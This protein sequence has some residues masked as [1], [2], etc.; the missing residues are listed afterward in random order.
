[1]VEATVIGRL[2]GLLRRSEAV[3]SM[4]DERATADVN[5][6]S[7]IS[8]GDRS[9]LKAAYVDLIDQ[10]LLA[11]ELTALAPGAKVLDFGCGV[12]RLACWS[13]FDRLQYFGVDRSQKMIDGAKRHTGE[14]PA[15]LF[16]HYDGDRLPFDDGTFDCVIA[17]WV[18]QH[19][20]DEQSL[21]RTARE[22]DRVSR[23]GGKIILI[24]QVSEEQIDEALPSG[25]IYKRHRPASALSE[26]FGSRSGPAWLRKTDG[27]VMHGPFYRGLA[28]LG[29][30]P[31]AG[32]RK[33]VP[34]FVA[35]DDAWYRA[36]GGLRLPSQRWL[37]QGLMIVKGR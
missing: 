28:L 18:I 34:S 37:D 20:V 29:R 26:A 5:F 3:T 14:R 25:E 35:L 23:P 33:L 21:A 11:A 8:P 31:I 17:I 7:V 1:M 2:R 22:L 10:R 24:E 6:N 30:L 13:L 19:I 4:W 15:R 36:T 16:A 9:G 32:L 12:G 27:F